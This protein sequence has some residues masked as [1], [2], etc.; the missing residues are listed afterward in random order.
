MPSAPQN[1]PSA[2]GKS[3]ETVS[4]VVP[5]LAAACSLNLRVEVAQVGVSMDG[6]I[7][8]TTFLPANSARLTGLSCASMRVNAGALLPTAG[9]SPAVVTGLPRNNV[10]AILIPLCGL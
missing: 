4:T 9:S 1:R 5:A 8:I 7:L 2:K 6:K 10:C 3:S